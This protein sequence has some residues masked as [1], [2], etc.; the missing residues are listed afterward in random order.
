MTM[1]VPCPT[2]RSRSSGH[3]ERK[4]KS[5]CWCLRPRFQ[6][7]PRRPGLD[8]RQATTN[9]THMRAHGS[10]PLAYT[11][12]DMDMPLMV[13]CRRKR[14]GRKGTERAVTTNSRWCPQFT[15]THTHTHTPP[16][17]QKKLKLNTPI[18]TPLFKYLAA[19]R[20]ARR[21]LQSQGGGSSERVPNRAP[22]TPTPPPKKNPIRPAHL[23]RRSPGG[24]ARRAT[25]SLTRR[26]TRSLTRRATRSL[27]R[28]VTSVARERPWLWLAAGL[29]AINNHQQTRQQTQTQSRRDTYGTTSSL[30]G[31]KTMCECL[32][33]SK[34]AWQVSGRQTRTE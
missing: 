34:D 12:P 5:M 11:L 24:L 19:H 8:R 15:H 14:T 1:T 32:R 3:T 17:L 27:A 13:I 2:S 22:T 6:Q 9:T 10:L 4:T 23:A 20:H 33:S 21:R 7:R 31:L 28:L 29:A 18:T 16:F 25:G 30:S 26:A